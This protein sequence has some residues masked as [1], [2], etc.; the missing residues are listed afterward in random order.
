MCPARQDPEALF[1]SVSLA[2]AA[3][4]L[5]AD[6]LSRRKVRA[7]LREH[8]DPVT[9]WRFV[10]GRLSGAA[11][12]ARQEECRRHGIGL[13]R[14][15]EP[16]FPEVLTRIPDAPL[17]LY[18]RGSQDPSQAISVA[19]VGARRAGRYGLELARS[20]AADLAGRGV[21]VVSGLALGIDGAAHR[22]ALDAGGRTV[23]VLGSGLGRV[24]PRANLRLAEEIVAAG[25][26]L[27]AEY[28]PDRSGARH[29]FP[30]RNRL[31]S[32]LCN[33]VVV[34][35]ASARSGSLITAGFA[36]EQG[37]EVMAVPGTPGLPNSAGAN[38]LLKDGAALV[39]NAD[40]V[41][42]ALGLAG[43]AA[44]GTGDPRPLPL[45][46]PLVAVLDQMDE[47][48]VTA[49]TLAALLGV[50]IADVNVRLT[51]LELRGFVARVADGYIRRP[52]GL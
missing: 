2:A 5:L 40:D 46:A 42:D 43:V 52:L 17:A 33:G 34:I 29:Q 16:G 12:A 51:E 14:E 35:E 37:R 18:R 3:A 28:P 20:L 24:Q 22:G 44:P 7:L 39:E 30:E 1:D 6:N 25:G 11:T 47:D 9:A 32:G 10:G 50:A 36:M 27:I 41:L 38:R 26:A 23:A 48:A 45:S 13:V 21:C 8:G 15:G 19:I 31:I 4:S 49:D